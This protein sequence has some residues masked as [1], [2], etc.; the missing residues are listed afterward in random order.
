LLFYLIEYL[1]FK[2]IIN[3]ARSALSPLIYYKVLLRFKPL[4]SIYISSYL[5]SVFIETL[6]EYN[7]EDKVFSRDKIDREVVK[8]SLREYKSIIIKRYYL[9]KLKAVKEKREEKLSKVKKDKP[10]DKP[11]DII[12]VI[13]KDKLEDIPEERPLSINISIR[14]K[15]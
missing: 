4:Y 5:S 13:I 14:E 6:A 11:G 9:D 3:K 10:E 12:K 8:A 1:L 2:Y 15:M 7:I